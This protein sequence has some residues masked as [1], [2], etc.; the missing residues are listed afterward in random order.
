MTLPPPQAK[1]PVYMYKS[2]SW[3]D[4]EVKSYDPDNNKFTVKVLSNGQ[5]KTI[6]KLS[7][8]FNFE[9]KVEF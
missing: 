3:Q 6:G 1:S 5:I 2:Y 9:D 4:V 7:L 8:L